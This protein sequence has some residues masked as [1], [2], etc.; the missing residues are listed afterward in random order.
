M[1]ITNSI[2]QGEVSAGKS[3]LL[4]LLLGEALLPTSLLS[5]T[6]VICEVKY[7]QKKSAKLHGWEDGKSYEFLDLE[8][9][10]GSGTTVSSG[11]LKQLATSVRQTDQRS[12]RHRYKRVEIFW[13]CKMLKVLKLFTDMY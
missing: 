8:H 6:A 12:L 10:E 5:C 9:D 4:N 1:T 13:P 2:F 11:C 3:S 7:S